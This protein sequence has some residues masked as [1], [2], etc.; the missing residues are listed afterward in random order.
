MR[1]IL[2]SVL[3]L[4]TIQVFSQNLTTEDYRI[5]ETVICNESS[6]KI[7]VESMC[8]Y[9]ISKF[10]FYQD[11]SFLDKEKLEGKI[12]IGHTPLIEKYDKIPYVTILN[13]IDLDTSQINKY[14][15]IKVD[16]VFWDARKIKCKRLVIKNS[17]RFEKLGY[18]VVRPFRNTFSSIKFRTVGRPIYLD[19]N[20][21]LI[22]T[23]YFNV[24]K[25]KGAKEYEVDLY[26]LQKVDNNW[27]IK[28]RFN[29]NIH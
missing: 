7:K 22:N 29:F 2:I 23:A 1:N 27:I 4:T 14:L 13:H 21:V 5:L 20:N 3:L 17:L 8:F 25:G 24:K 12:R 10:D 16:G 28:E 26:Y 15:D 9:S 18:K 6:K 11:S 19:K